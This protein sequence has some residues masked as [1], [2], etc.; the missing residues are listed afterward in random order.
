VHVEIITK[1]THF[2]QLLFFYKRR[3]YDLSTCAI[4]VKLSYAKYPVFD[5]Y[6]HNS[7]FRKVL[8]EESFSLVYQIQGL[9]L[10]S[11]SRR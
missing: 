5:I 10:S 2:E 8:I 3:L 4:E 6:L 9:A 1:K 11:L 7:S